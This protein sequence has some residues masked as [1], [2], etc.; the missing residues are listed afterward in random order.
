MIDVSGLRRV[1]AEG[2]LSREDLTGEPMD[3]FEKW[4]RQAIDSGMPDPT[5]MVVSTVDG[6]GQPSSRMVLLKNY[7]RKS[8]V[9]FTNYGSRK[10]LQLLNN[11]RVAILFPWFMLE[12][13][14]AFLGHA[15]KL[16]PV[17]VVKY[18][19]SRPRDSQIGAWT[20]HQSSRISARAAL[21]SKFM[22]LKQ[23][24]SKGEIPVPTFWGGFRVFFHSVE[25]WQGRPSR[26]HDRFIYE[27]NAAGGWDISRLAP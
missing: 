20:S 22:E 6:E 27:R 25:F 3:L 8:L 18:F 7:D 14:V 19:T 13:Q 15:E 9:F 5:G 17:E 26:L 16:T 2:G 12:R 23:K 1:Y 10:A 24:F 4:L 11:P 21:E